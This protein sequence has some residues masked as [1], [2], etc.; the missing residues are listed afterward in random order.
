MQREGNRPLSGARGALRKSNPNP[1]SLSSRNTF[2]KMSPRTA[3]FSMHSDTFPAN[4]ASPRH[5]RK[6]PERLNSHTAGPTERETVLG[7]RSRPGLAKPYAATQTQFLW[8]SC[9]TNQREMMVTF[10]EASFGHQALGHLLSMETSCQDSSIHCPGFC[11][12]P[13]GMGRL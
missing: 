4:R 13:G 10:T 8:G 11:C 9:A 6:G 12:I 7:F 2:D 5:R 3:Q 1:V